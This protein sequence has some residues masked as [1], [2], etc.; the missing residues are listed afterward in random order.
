MNIGFYGPNKFSI[1]VLTVAKFDN[2]FDILIMVF[3]IPVIEIQNE[4][5]YVFCQVYNKH[6]LHKQNFNCLKKLYDAMMQILMAQLYA[7]VG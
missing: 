4:K 1:Y 2:F 3:G 6:E 5:Q 7:R